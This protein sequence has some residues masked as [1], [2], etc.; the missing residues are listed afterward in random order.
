[1]TASNAFSSPT[2]P[3]G[4]GGGDPFD[5]TTLSST[6]IVGIQSLIIRSGRYVDSIQATYLLADGTV[7]TA[8]AHGGS[9]GNPSRINLAAGET[10]IGISGRAGTLL[11]QISITT[12]NVA[13]TSKIYGPYG[14]GGGNDF[15]LDGVVTGF[16]GRSGEY[17]DA[18]AFYLDDPTAGYFGGAGGTSFSDPVLTMQPLVIAI[19]SITIRSGTLVDSLQVTYLRADGSTYTTPQ[20]GGDGGAAATITFVSGEHI[21]A[22][23][24]S[25]GEYVNQLAFLT[26]APN[27]KRNTYGPYPSG[28]SGGNAFIVNSNVLGFFGRSGRYLDAIAAYEATSNLDIVVEGSDGYYFCILMSQENRNICAIPVRNSS[29]TDLS[30][31]LTDVVDGVNPVS[32]TVTA[33]DGAVYSSA[34]SGTGGIWAVSAGGTAG[35]QTFYVQNPQEGTWQATVTAPSGASW[36]INGATNQATGHADAESAFANLPPDS[37]RAIYRIIQPAQPLPPEICYFC[38][39]QA[40]VILGL[41]AATFVFWAG[42]VTATSMVVLYAERLLGGTVS[43]IVSTINTLFSAWSANKS[44]SPLVRKFCE[45]EGMCQASPA[46]LHERSK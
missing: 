42:P 39:A 37:A 26:E 30:F 6:P 24:G 5:D 25:S 22:L 41:A 17:V 38:Q 44:I 14:G 34:S 32:F 35:L 33:P 7:L 2:Y 20:H 29:A 31:R 8:P 19:S 11:D 1:M 23:L 45:L 18:L 46:L 21:I 15:V 43:S 10:I 12:R 9:G 13:G 28:A 27:G 16:M 40:Y 36:S 3:T 4:A